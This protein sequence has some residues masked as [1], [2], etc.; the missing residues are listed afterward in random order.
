MIGARLRARV[1]NHADIDIAGSVIFEWSIQCDCGPSI[2]VKRDI[3]FKHFGYRPHD[4]PVSAGAE[5]ALVGVGDVDG[6]VS[7]GC[8]SLA[9]AR[10]AI[11]GDLCDSTV[12]VAQLGGGVDLLREGIGGADVGRYVLVRIRAATQLC[13]MLLFCH[14]DSLDGNVA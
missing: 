2:S 7:G 11:V 8:R 12:L 9:A 3:A 13:L 1:V 6:Q 4:L 5:G 10:I 14:E